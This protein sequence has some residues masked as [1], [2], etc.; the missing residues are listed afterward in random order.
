MSSAS[1][2]SNYSPLAAGLT[3]ANLA[4]WASGA[5]LEAG[6]GAEVPSVELQPSFM[7]LEMFDGGEARRRVLRPERGELDAAEREEDA[8]GSLRRGEG[9]RH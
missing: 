6:G 2:A 8:V 3:P 4:S 1:I 5:A 9:E 7:P